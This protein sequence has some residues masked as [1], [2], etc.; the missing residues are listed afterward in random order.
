MRSKR[1]KRETLCWLQISVDIAEGARLH[2][3][4]PFKAEVQVY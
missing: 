1:I 4:N 2:A 3:K